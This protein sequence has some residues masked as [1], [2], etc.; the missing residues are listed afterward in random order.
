MK[1]LKEFVGHFKGRSVFSMRDCRVFLKQKGISGQYLQFLVQYLMKKGTIK[2]IAKGV[3]TFSDDP[4]V[5][6]FAFAPFYYGLQEALS[7]HDLW[8]QETN[9]VVITTRKARQGTRKILGSNVLV[10]RIDKKMFF[11]F[12]MVSHFGLWIPVSGIEK[13]LIDFVYF[14]EKIPEEALGEIKKR[15]RKNVL[16]DHLKKLKPRMKK[17]V[18][19]ALGVL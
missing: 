6:G 17:R 10:R 9:P 5:A 16:E 4:I 18:K 15:I 19:K 3:Y 12:E 1:Y 7:L 11:G 13:T 14:N 2:R 8:E